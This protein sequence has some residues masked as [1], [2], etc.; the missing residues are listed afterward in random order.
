MCEN[1]AP[2]LPV[3]NSLHGTVDI[4]QHFKK[5]GLS[6]YVFL[7]ASLLAARVAGVT[8]SLWSVRVC[9]SFCSCV[10]AV[11]EHGVQDFMVC[12]CV[13]VCV[14]VRVCVCMRVRVRACVRGFADFI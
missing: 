14:F 3:P 2:G 10:A 6:F 12:V 11:L 4:K 8:S 7:S 13:C 9:C 5:E 1:R